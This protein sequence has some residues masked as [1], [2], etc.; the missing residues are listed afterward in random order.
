MK[1]LQIKCWLSSLFFIIPLASAYSCTTIFSNTNN[2]SK[3]VARSTDLYISDEPL[4]KVQPRGMKRSGEAGEHSL[5]WKSKYGN[6]VVTAFHTNVVSDGINEKGLAAHILYLSE[7]QYPSPTKDSMQIS[8]LM[9]AQYVLDNYATVQEALDGTKDLQIIAT[10]V[11]DR[12]WPL[13]LTIEDASGDSA[14]IEF[15]A[16]KMKVYQ[17]KQYQVMTNEP[18]YTV[19]LTNLKRYQ[20]FGGK[21]PLPG[22][23]DPLSRFVRAS[24]FLKTLTPPNNQLE[25]IAG[26][27]S[28]MRT[29]MVPF[30]AVDVSGNNTEDAWQTRWVT[31]ADLTNKVYYFNSTSTPNIIWV[32]LNK[33]DFSEQ[34]KTLMINPTDV[35]LVGDISAR[36]APAQ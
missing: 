8:N 7:S 28:V 33:V 11:K 2:I 35:K 12:T 17:G 15:L 6:V 24:A 22:D 32:D 16:G 34:A 36:M 19:Q 27:L 1:S 5:N 29:V 26:V 10:K 31:V 13:H 23:P 20:G 9:W 21:L 3:V 4:I 14:I 18:A 25:S 30:G